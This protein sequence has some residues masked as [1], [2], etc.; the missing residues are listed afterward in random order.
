[1]SQQHPEIIAASYTVWIAP[2]G[3]A[4]PAIDEAPT[5]A[6]E[7]LGSNGDR[8]YSGAGLTV[9]HQRQYAK[10]VQA[11]ET[12]DGAVMIETEELRLTGELVDVT[13]EQYALVLGGNAVTTVAAGPGVPGT[14]TLGLSVRSGLS[15]E[16]ALLVRGPSPYD[17]TKLMQYELPR[18][19]E[20][21]GPQLTY[22][23]AVATGIAF[24]I[25]VLP[26]AAATSEE[27]RFGR[28][29]AQFAD[30]E[31]EPPILGGL[32]LGSESIKTATGNLQVA[33]Q[34]SVLKQ[35]TT[36]LTNILTS[37][38]TFLPV[39]F[40]I[41]FDRMN[42]NST[43]AMLGNEPG[44]VQ[45][46]NLRLAFLPDALG[47]GFGTRRGK[48]EVS[49]RRNGGATPDYTLG[50]GTMPKVSGWY[51][52]WIRRTGDVTKID[53][54]DMAGTKVSDGTASAL[55]QAN[56]GLNSFLESH[57]YIGDARNVSGEATTSTARGVDT[58]AVV[59]WEGAFAFV[60]WGN[61]AVSDADCQ[62]IALGADP[63]TRI[64]ASNFTF[65]RRF[66]DTGTTS[67]SPVA[68]TSDTSAATTV[69]GTFLPGGTPG[70]Q[71]TTDWIT[72]NPVRDY[73]NF[74]IHP[75]TREATVPF[76]GSCGGVAFSGTITQFL[77]PDYRYRRE[78][79]YISG[80]IQGRFITEAGVPVGAWQTV[81]T[82]TATGI[83][84]G[85]TFTENSR[86]AAGIK[87]MANGQSQ[88]GSFAKGTSL[89]NTMPT[90]S[91]SVVRLEVGSVEPTAVAFQTLAEVGNNRAADG[92]AQL[93]K[94]VQAGAIATLGQSA[95]VEVIFNAVDG[96][97]ISSMID[98]WVRGNL[99]TLNLLAYSSNDL[100]IDLYN[101]HSTDV[102]QLGNFGTNVLGAAYLGTGPLATANKLPDI[103]SSTARIVIAVATRETTTSAGPFDTDQST[104]IGL[105]RQSA[106]SW[107]AAN[108]AF[109]APDQIDMK[110]AASNGPHQDQAS[111]RGNPRIFG[112]M[113]EGI[114]RALGFSTSVDPS[115]GTP[116]FV[117][118]KASFTLTATLPNAGSSLRVDN[119]ATYGSNVQGFEIST[120][121]GT[122]WSRSGFTA[123]FS[124]TTVTLTKSSGNWA[125]VTVGNMRVRYAWGGPFSYGTS[126]EASE[127]F[128][129]LLYDGTALESNLGL[130]LQ[131]LA[132][133]VVAE[134]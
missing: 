25:K 94:V 47:S 104:G 77:L 54:Y 17:E 32:E 30:A 91:V 89:N 59:G 125:G 20:A 85:R 99:N 31:A 102:G 19:C 60:G 63:L 111:T 48:F 29:V 10:A 16:F 36:G 51:D 71:S 126:L 38:N 130:P 107:A 58:N 119:T 120:D 87:V 95:A 133:T 41:D 53:V 37:G 3:T 6:W 98:D 14:K 96:T 4:F 110:L 131:P 57:F 12:A 52:L 22:R 73:H 33:G 134:P 72:L 109:I 69:I 50:S 113:G 11:G 61:A 108:G 44:S 114:N 93:A 122:T 43:Y 76:A 112:R 81:A 103:R 13:L 18:C 97:G 26:D 34:T 74:A 40:Y 121:G 21:G 70:R 115:L 117:A 106:R 45:P 39:R 90:P 2:V 42:Q 78:A 84:D 66:R 28:V 83:T 67:R 116:R 24:S 127:E 46:G 80:T 56:F 15:R 123:T 23:R 100:T 55:T 82:T 64:G 86:S 105:V 8:N 128:R 88:M 79:R 49:V 132:S 62:A 124:G 68:G 101:W 1:M 92:V 27:T 5:A 129:G 35:S 118:G 9:S 65:Y 75:V 7:T